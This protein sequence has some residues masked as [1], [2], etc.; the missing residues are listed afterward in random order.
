MDDTTLASD[1][2]EVDYEKSVKSGWIVYK[3][4]IFAMFGGVMSFLLYT[5]LIV[6]A[7]L[8][9]LSELND[10]SI[11]IV[12][13]AL[14]LFVIFWLVSNIIFNNV[15]VKVEG[16]SREDNK[17]T[18][19]SIIDDNFSSFDFIINNEKVMRSFKPVGSP[20]WGR[21]ITILFEGDTIYLN[22]TTLGRSNSPTMIHGLL[23][24]IKAK[25]I[26]RYYRLHYS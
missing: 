22:I 8:G 12:N 21:I 24:Y 10:H 17:A 6:I 1:S 5:F 3:N 14:P 11:N 15:L 9:L 2:P 7:S 23:N 16:K 13:I 19:L 26:A 25:R 18:I 4:S 20:M